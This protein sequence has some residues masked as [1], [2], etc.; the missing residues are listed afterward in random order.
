MRMRRKKHLEERMQAVQPWFADIGETTGGYDGIPFEAAPLDLA[1]I[2]GNDRPVDL[3]IGCGKGQ[4]AAEYAAQNPQRNLLAVEINGNVIVQAAEKA[5]AASLGNLR[6]LRIGAQHLGVLLKKDSIQR[7]FLNFSCPFPKKRQQKR[8]LTHPDFL[9]LYRGF[10]AQDG[11][12]MQKTDNAQ[13]FEFSLCALSGCGFVLREVSLDL[14][15]SAVEGNIMT[16][17]EQRFT[18]LGQPIYYLK[19]QK[20]GRD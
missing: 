5:K 10:L 19:A 6:F 3:E 16:E 11:L 17:Y 18:A 14:H 13:L 9:K 7:I 1:A 8:R 4:F 12:L 20:H 2:F 15:H